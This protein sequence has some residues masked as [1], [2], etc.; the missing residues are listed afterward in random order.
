MNPGD[1]E[2]LDVE[3]VDPGAGPNQPLLRII[4]VLLRLETQ[5]TRRTFAFVFL[6]A[7]GIILV[8]ENPSRFDRI[9]LRKIAAVIAAAIASAAVAADI[10]PSLRS[11]RH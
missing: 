1:L 9:R 2:G 11:L 10:R 4:L 8:L 5:S 7:C 6:V 3:G